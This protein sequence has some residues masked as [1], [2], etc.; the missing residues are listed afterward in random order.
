MVAVI[1]DMTRIQSRPSAG[2]SEEERY[3][4]FYETKSPWVLPARAWLDLEPL[5]PCLLFLYAISK[6]LVRAFL[7]P[8]QVLGTKEGIVLRVQ[9]S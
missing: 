1:S 9:F 2:Q 7:M 4:R 8:G 6:H 3:K 5:S